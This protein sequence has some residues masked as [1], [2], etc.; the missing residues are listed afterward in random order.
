M[1]GHV[2]AGA[3]GDPADLGDGGLGQ[4]VQGE[5]DVADVTHHA[6][7]VRR[8]LAFAARSPGRRPSRSRRLRR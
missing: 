8:L 6:E 2:H 7:R 5:A 1:Q 3:H 4:A